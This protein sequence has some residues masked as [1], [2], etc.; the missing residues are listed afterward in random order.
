MYIHSNN[1]SYYTHGGIKFIPPWYTIVY[2]CILPVTTWQR[3]YLSK[4]LRKFD[5]SKMKA[6][7]LV[8]L[9]IILF[10]TF[11]PS[12]IAIS[13]VLHKLFAI[14]WNHLTN[15]HSKPHKMCKNVS[16][17]NFLS[18]KDNYLKLSTITHNDFLFPTVSSFW[19]TSWR[20]FNF[21]ENYVKFGALFW[22]K[23]RSRDKNPQIC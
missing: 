17:N 21:F 5:E 14:I 15:I 11:M 20:I 13:S 6:C 22:L 16:V 23:Y 10:S 8:S 7:N 9:T 12:F 18:T 2:I 19:R 1:C 4:F 3:L